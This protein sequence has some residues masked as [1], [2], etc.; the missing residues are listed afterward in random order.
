MS[1]PLAYRGALAHRGAHAAARAFGRVDDRAASAYRRAAEPSAGAAAA[2]A[3]GVCLIRP[4]R[5]APVEQRTLA[6][7]YH[8]PRAGA[9]RPERGFYAVYVVSLELHGLEAAAA[10]EP[11]G[12]SPALFLV[13]YD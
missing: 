4:A 8:G 9:L 12:V 5:A 10:A 13:D 7:D 6:A 2:A 3:V 11:G 1:R